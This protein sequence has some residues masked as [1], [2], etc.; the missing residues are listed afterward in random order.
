LDES[1]SENVNFCG[2][3]KLRLVIGVPSIFLALT[4]AGMML[5]LWF[6]FIDQS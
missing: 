1:K 6:M 2:V 3:K 5:I 4:G